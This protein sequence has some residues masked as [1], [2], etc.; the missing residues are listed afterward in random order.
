MKFCW[1]QPAWLASMPS[2]SIDWL[3]VSR[4]AFASSAVASGGVCVRAQE[5]ARE[6]QTTRQ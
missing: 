1:T 6:R 2:F 5:R 4:N 3:T